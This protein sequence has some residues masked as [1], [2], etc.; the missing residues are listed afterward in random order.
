MSEE[1]VREIFTRL[2]RLG[3][4]DDRLADYQHWDQLGDEARFRTAWEL[5]VQ[6]YELQGRSPNEL[7]FQRSVTDLIKKWG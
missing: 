2:G 6:A 1:K 7:R 4:D 3:E 5:V